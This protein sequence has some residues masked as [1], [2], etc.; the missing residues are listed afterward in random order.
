MNHPRARTSDPGVSH[1]A[2]ASVDRFVGTHYDRIYTALD[3]FGAQTKDEIATRTGLT[4][5]QVDRR[6]P[7]MQRDGDVEPTG[8]HRASKSGRDERV[9]RVKS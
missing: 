7:E 2:A 4:P 1:A 6:L 8:E 3:K 9:W 5:V